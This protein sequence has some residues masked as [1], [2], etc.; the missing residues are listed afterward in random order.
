M[1]TAR[2]P[3]TAAGNGGCRGLKQTVGMKD[4]MK[5]QSWRAALKAVICSVG[6]HSVKEH[7]LGS[8]RKAMAAVV[9]AQF[10]ASK[11]TPG[12]RAGVLA[13]ADNEHIFQCL[14]AVGERPS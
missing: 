8:Y 12:G 1:P 4:M 6:K 5:M 2:W 14:C 3:E 10:S 7:Y 13:L 11:G 9:R